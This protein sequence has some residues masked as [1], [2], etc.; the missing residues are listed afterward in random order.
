MTALLCPRLPYGG[1]GII[2]NT[3]STG[4]FVAMNP[5]I[6]FAAGTMVADGMRIRP[7]AFWASAVAKFRLA[8]GRGRASLKSWLRSNA[9]GFDFFR[10]EA[11]AIIGRAVWHGFKKPRFFKVFLKKNLKSPNLGFLGFLENKY[12]MSDLSFKLFFTYYATNLIEMLSN[13]PINMNCIFCVHMAESLQSAL[14]T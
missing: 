11:T 1:G 8:D 10:I 2:R 12:L 5:G 7:Q 4:N 6:I 3:G 13:F 14:H 9:L